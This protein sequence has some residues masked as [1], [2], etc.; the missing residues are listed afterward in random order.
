MPWDIDLIV[1]EDNIEEEDLIE[2]V[3]E[4]V[5]RKDMM[6]IM[7]IDTQDHI[8]DRD[9]EVEIDTGKNVDHVHTVEVDRDQGKKLF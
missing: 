1:V 7:M 5:I 3:V 6:T 9:P 2:V 8:L 4:E